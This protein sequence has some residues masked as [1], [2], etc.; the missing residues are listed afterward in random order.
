MSALAK[1]AKENGHEVSGSD[2][3]LHGHNPENVR[4]CDMVV[5]SLA[6]SEDNCELC[7][8]RQLSIPT[9]SRSEYLA[10]ISKE[11]DTFFAVCGCHGKTTTTAMLYST[12]KNFAPTLHIGAEV[13]S[14]GGKKGIFISEACEYKKSFLSLHP[15]F[16][17][18]TNV[19]YDHPDC[20]S[21]LSELKQAYLQFYKQ[22][23]TCFIN[24][25]DAHSKFLLKRKNTVSYGF[26]DNA[27]F[28]ASSLR[29]TPTGYTF[30]LNY[31]KHFLCSFTM[32]VKGRH[33]VYN[34]L[35]AIACAFSFGVN[36][37]DV[38]SGIMKFEGVKRRNEFL[39]SIDNGDIFT[40]YAHHPT[41]ITNQ[42]SLL[43]SFY[44]SV[45]IV[46][47]PHTY[48]RTANLLSD[49]AF[50]LSKAS[51]VVLLPTFA[52]R[53]QGKDDDKLYNLLKSNI[54]VVNIEKND[55]NQWVKD[56][57]KNYSCICYTGAGDIDKEARKLFS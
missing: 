4:N 52:S 9:L 27:E 14:V 45:A 57:A 39:G 23:G 1:I 18:F 11:Y 19:D 6:I 8:A 13:D 7:T 41:E 38:R 46:F 42:L 15:D 37:N 33:N 44:K 29:P 2:L 30:D 32:S 26:S 35:G 20:Y 51:C 56:N 40:D 24:A 12:L 50:S 21:S 5:Y 36:K 28:Q 31:K 22:S 53:E 48:S 17:I 10:R 54:R 3:T 16:T 55:V 47:Q 49:F 34:A 43:A 25:D